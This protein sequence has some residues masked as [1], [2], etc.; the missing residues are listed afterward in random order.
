MGTWKVRGFKN[1]TR[2]PENLAESVNGND[3]LA[4]LGLSELT[5]HAEVEIMMAGYM[6]SQWRENRVIDPSLIDQAIEHT[7][8]ALN[9][10]QEIVRRETQGR[11]PV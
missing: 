9:S 10:L 8:W 2:Q 3:R 11:P 6:L 5:D 4:R 1:R 7:Q